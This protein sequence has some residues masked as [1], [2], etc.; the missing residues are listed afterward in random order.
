MQVACPAISDDSFLSSVLA[1]LDCQAQNLGAGGYQALANPGGPAALLLTGALTLFIALIGYRLLL[2]ETPSVR[3]GVVAAI[4]VGV[5]LALATS[6]PAFRTLAYD[7]TLRAPAEVASNIGSPAGLPGAPGGLVARLQLVDYQLAELNVV[8]TGR[9]LNANVAVGPTANLTPAQ[10]AAELRRVQDLGNRARWDPQRD[11]SLLG[12]ARALFLSGAIASFAS[13]RLVAGLLLA[14]GPLFVIFLLFD[15]TRGLFEGWVR[16]LTGAALG[17]LATAIVLGVELA[18]L[19]PW[20]AAV[21]DLRHQNIATPS[22]PVELL[23]LTLVFAVTLIAV[24][25]AVGKVAAGFRLPPAWRVLRD[26]VAAGI[27]GSVTLRDVQRAGQAAPQDE[28]GR[29]LVIADAVSA[30]QRRE[31]LAAQPVAASFGGRPGI[32]PTASNDV[33][34][35][36]AVPLGQSFRR[37]TRGRVSAGASRRDSNR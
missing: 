9:P 31:S 34:V 5:V 16:G 2:G 18:L 32:T 4:K 23:V 8:G 26:R 14:L 3:D 37:R 12:S 1:H 20:L 29:A 22:V 28:R 36:G 24:L 19:E 35:A 6:W 15:G 10:Q 27:A 7:I 17:A 11:F 13:V 33:A 30:T 21:L 25:V